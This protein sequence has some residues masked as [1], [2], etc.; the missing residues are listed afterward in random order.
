MRFAI[1]GAGGVGAYFGA[2]LARAGH[3][4][5]YVARGAQLEAL[6][7]RPL[8]IECVTVGNFSVKVRAEERPEDLGPADVVLFAVKSYDTDSALPHVRPLLGPNTMVLGL[9][10]GLDGTDRLIE[11]CGRDRV[12]GAVCYI[13]CAVE[14]PGLVAHRAGPNRFVFGELGGGKSPRTEALYDA[15]ATTGAKA[16]LHDNVSV[17]IWTKFTVICGYSGALALGRCGLGVLLEDRAGRELI[18]GSIDE[19]VRCGRAKQIAL[20]DD[21]T[22]RHMKFLDGFERHAYSSMERDLAGGRRLEVDALNG[23]VVRLG[24]ELGVPTPYNTTTYAAL[25]PFANG[26]P[27]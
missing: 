18:E 6:R 20:P 27:R 15:F 1:I 19:V 24:R 16:E 22:A 4:V 17:G 14:R 5:G 13:N 9:Q 26:P 10:N 21:L 2:L 12:V 23:T 3:D 11:V 7:S 8:E 25:K